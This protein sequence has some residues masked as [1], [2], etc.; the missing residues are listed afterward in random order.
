MKI[1]APVLA[2]ALHARVVHMS[3]VSRY[4]PRPINVLSLRSN[5]DMQLPLSYYIRRFAQFVLKRKKLK[6]KLNKKLTKLR[7]ALIAS[8]ILSTFCIKSN[9]YHFQIDIIPV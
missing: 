7:L 2:F 9:L 3:P 8:Y 5:P 4:R 6:N 1:H